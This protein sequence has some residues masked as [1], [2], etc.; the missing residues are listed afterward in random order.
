[1]RW[2][3]ETRDPQSVTAA[4]EAALRHVASG[5]ERYLADLIDYVRIPSVSTD[6]DRRDDVAAAARWTEERLR[7]AGVPDVRTLATGGH[8][9]VVGRLHHD[10]QLPTV[11][12]YGHHDVQPA[13]P[14]ELWHSP[15]FEPE[16]RDGMVYGR[17]S[18]DDK[19]G[20]LTAIQ[21]V[22]A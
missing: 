18:C 3:V 12:V 9:V 21:A 15:P 8:P 11:I 1:I 22:E 6:P 17:G 10:P 16:V 5:E 4:L 19:A 7:R 20:V 2:S 13:E 14:L